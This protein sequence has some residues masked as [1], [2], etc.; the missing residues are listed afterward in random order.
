M[1][2]STSQQLAV[3]KKPYGVQSATII[4]L[5]RGNQMSNQKTIFV[6]LSAAKNLSFSTAEIRNEAALRSE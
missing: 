3:R 6:I 1:G 4:F 2:I 5:N